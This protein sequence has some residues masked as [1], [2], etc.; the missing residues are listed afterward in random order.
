MLLKFKNPFS[1]EGNNKNTK[2]K[3][4]TYG[5]SDKTSMNVGLQILT[6][7]SQRKLNIVDKSA[8]RPTQKP[9][10]SNRS[11]SSEY[12]FLKSCHLCNKELCLDKDVY[13]YRGDEGFCSIECRDRKI[14][15][16][17]MEE[18]E[19]LA[20]QRRA[21][22]YKHCSTARRRGTRRTGTGDELAVQHSHHQSH[23]WT[24]TS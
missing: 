14:Y 11:S 21:A 19:K 10:S 23:Q 1:M 22:K 3:S 6:Q 12:C 5:S 4:S 16:D 24:I 20:K 18:L 7:R 17:E 13:M 8:L 15:L 9:V 2:S